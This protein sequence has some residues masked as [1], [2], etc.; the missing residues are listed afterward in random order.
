MFQGFK[1]INPLYQRTKSR[2]L[3]F[4]ESDCE[5]SSLLGPD[6]QLALYILLCKGLHDPK[7]SENFNCN[8]AK[9]EEISTATT[10][11]TS[12]AATLN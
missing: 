3:D 6:F 11:L 10:T 1:Y 7:G 4:I 5:Q 9:H 2:K 12:A 8:T